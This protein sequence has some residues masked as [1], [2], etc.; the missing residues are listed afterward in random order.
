MSVK[1]TQ[2][3]N[4]LHFTDL[5][6]IRFEDLCLAIVFPLYPWLDIQH[7]GRLGSDGGVDIVASQELEDHSTRTWFVQ[8]RRYSK[9]TKATLRKAVDDALSRAA[10]TPDVLLVILACDVRREANEEYKSY[11][12]GRGVVVPMLWTASLLE[13]RLSG[14]RKDLLFSYF[15]ISGAQRARSKEWATRRNFAMKRRV[16]RELIKASLTAEDREVGPWGKFIDSEAYIHSVDDTSYPE[17]EQASVGIDG[18][19]KARFCDLY[20]NGIEFFLGGAESAAVDPRGR[21]AIVP[22][23]EQ[24]KEETLTE[25]RV[26]RVGRLPYRNIV[27]I[28]PSGDEHYSYPHIYCL[29][30]DAGM[31]WERFIYRYAECNRY[32]SLDEGSRVSYDELVSSA[33]TIRK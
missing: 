2:T 30:A 15:G 5:A 21:W 19:F 12:L 13:A 22:Y 11:A 28:D 9:A 27:E 14:E 6:P 23:E 3:T 4:R 16:G 18:W 31:P 24:V 33:R 25:M 7:H 1:P 8:C 26:F 10:S 32:L 20:F 17:R 29:F